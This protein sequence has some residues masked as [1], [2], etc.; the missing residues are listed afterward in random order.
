MWNNNK[1]STSPR[2]E[3]SKGGSSPGVQLPAASVK[4]LVPETIFCL[5]HPVIG[6]DHLVK[7]TRIFHRSLI[8]GLVQ[9]GPRAD[10][11]KWSDMSSP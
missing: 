8:K 1:P 11:Y 5:K 3:G 6:I 2:K 10:R 4:G 7:K 9:A